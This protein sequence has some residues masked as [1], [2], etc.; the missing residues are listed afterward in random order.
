M[1]GLMRLGHQGSVQCSVVVSLAES[2]WLEARALAA[3]GKWRRSVADAAFPCSPAPLTDLHLTAHY[4]RQGDQRRAEGGSAKCC[5]QAPNCLPS[6]PW[7]GAGSLQAAQRCLLWV[8]LLGA[9]AATTASA[10]GRLTPARTRDA[11]PPAW[12]Q[13]AASAPESGTERPAE[14]GGAAT[15]PTGK[16]M[17]SQVRESSAEG[18][19]LSTPQQQ[20]QQP[21]TAPRIPHPCPPLLQEG[22]TEQNAPESGGQRDTTAGTGAAAEQKAA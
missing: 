12:L 9:T 13:E 16:M 11:P 14:Q 15:Q 6:S 1:P 19:L 4:E 17:S 7:T 20:A 8:G 10:A 22:Q 21:T 18:A 5:S 2:S 3:S